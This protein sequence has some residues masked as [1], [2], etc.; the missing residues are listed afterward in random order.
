MGAKEEFE[1][2]FIPGTTS[3]EMLKQ[4]FNITFHECYIADITKN[5]FVSDIFYSDGNELQILNSFQN[6]KKPERMSF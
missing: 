5:E 2:L 4:A 6:L 1:K 3:A